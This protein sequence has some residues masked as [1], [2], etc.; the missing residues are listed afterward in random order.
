[1]ASGSFVRP[2]SILAA[3]FFTS[4]SASAQAS[5]YVGTRISYDFQTDEVIL[6]ANLTVPI[7]TQIEFYPSLE[8]YLPDRGNKIGF[9][10]DVKVFLPTRA[11]YDLYAGGGLGVVNQNLGDVSNTDVGLNLLFGIG[12]RIGRIHPY[13]EARL[14]LHDDTQL[15][16]LAGVNFTLG[17]R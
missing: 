11:S 2:G 16:L 14:L 15:V 1:M 5:T 3:L 10:G 6:G 17:T 13:G 8:L 9:N 7:S 4:V 12:S